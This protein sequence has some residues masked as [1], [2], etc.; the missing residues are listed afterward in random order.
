MSY[1]VDG[2]H[3]KEPKSCFMLLIVE[4]NLITVELVAIVLDSFILY[5][6][7]SLLCMLT[8]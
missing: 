4:G 5:Q 3:S 6:D 1:Y 8:S 7:I 2:M